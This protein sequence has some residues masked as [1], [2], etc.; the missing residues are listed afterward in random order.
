MEKASV[1]L[2]NLKNAHAFCIPWFD[3][4]TNSCGF[5]FFF[6]RKTNS[7]LVLYGQMIQIS[8]TQIKLDRTYLD[9]S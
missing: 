3:G 9:P 8:P 5:L 2:D 7:L 4:E 6:V 1:F